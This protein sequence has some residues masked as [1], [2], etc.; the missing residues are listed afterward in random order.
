VPQHTIEIKA[1]DQVTAVP[2][3]NGET[4]WLRVL[5]GPGTDQMYVS[6]VAAEKLRDAITRALAELDE[7]ERA[8]PTRTQ[9]ER[10]ALHILDSRHRAELPARTQREIR[11]KLAA[12]ASNIAEAPS[13]K[14]E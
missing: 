2:P 13:E 12:S 8:A 6:R 10:A 1:N 3:M 14:R 7:I 5:Y 9:R 11:N 4:S